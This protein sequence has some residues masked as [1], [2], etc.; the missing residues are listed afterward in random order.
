MDKFENLAS[1][2]PSDFPSFMTIRNLI[3]LV[4]A[5]LSCPFF[6]RDSEGKIKGQ[7]A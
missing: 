5:S 6:K 1:M 2:S 7:T 4:D 3:M